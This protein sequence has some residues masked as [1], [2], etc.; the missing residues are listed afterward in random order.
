V[1]VAGS[2][3]EAVAANEEERERARRWLAEQQAP[4]IG[5]G[6]FVCPHCAA[7]AHQMWGEVQA[8]MAAGPRVVRESRMSLC[9]HCD[10]YAYWHGETLAYPTRGR[11]GPP[12]HVEMPPEPRGDYVE[13]QS[14]LDLSPRGAS[15][16]LRL[17][18]QKLMVALG[19][20][21]KDINADIG[22]LVKKGLAVEVQQ[23]LDSLRVIG[24]NAVHPGEMDLTDDRETALALFDVLNFIV[25]QRVAQPKKLQALYD[26][27][28]SG[29]KDAIE[30]RDTPK[31]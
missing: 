29:A 23:A 7:Y 4:A 8:N 25:E 13:A 31:A 20:K 17:A 12:P 28:P 27:L 15:A 19:E 11:A 3:L 24:N 16:L 18:L 5:K 14:I 21:G 2:R 6:A 30:K 9:A 22:A 26:R 10:G 1:A